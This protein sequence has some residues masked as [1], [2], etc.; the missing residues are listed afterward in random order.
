MLTSKAL[1]LAFASRCHN[2]LLEQIDMHNFKGLMMMN[3]W[4]G[5]TRHGSLV[6][7]QGLRCHD[8]V[9]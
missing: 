9:R 6:W 7:G 1:D 3:Q 8:N 2:Q 4:G 5:V